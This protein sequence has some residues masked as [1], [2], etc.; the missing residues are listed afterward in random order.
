MST[1][2][3]QELFHNVESTFET[4]LKEMQLNI[5]NRLKLIEEILNATKQKSPSAHHPELDKKLND[6]GQALESLNEYTMSQVRTLAYNHDM[7]EKRVES[8]ESSLRSASEALMTINNTIGSLQK[9]MDDERPVEAVEAEVEVEE[10]QEAALNAEV[11]ILATEAKAKATLAKAVETLAVEE[12]EEEEEEEVEDEVETGDEADNEEEEEELD[13]EAFTYKKKS[14]ARDQNNNV[15][16]VDEDGAADISEIVGIWNPTTKKID[17]V[18]QEEATPELEAFEYQKKT[19]CRDEKNNVY[20]VDDDGCA[21][22][23]EIVGIWNPKTKKIE[24]VPQA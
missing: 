8:M 17:P 9:R 23:S 12:E 11:D 7:L 5:H 19:Y 15:Y 2:V 20:S 18:P 22:I 6:L 3:I 16:T 10:T 24:R 13:L 21:D 4:N 1:E 14:Y